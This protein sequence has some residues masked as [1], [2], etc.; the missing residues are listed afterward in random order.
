M[1]LVTLL[2]DR[3]DPDYIFFTTVGTYGVCRVGSLYDRSIA[4]GSPL[5]SQHAGAAEHDEGGGL[6]ARAGAGPA[7][8]SKGGRGSH[9]RV[10]RDILSPHSCKRPRPFRPGAALLPLTAM[11]RPT[12]DPAP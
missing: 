5:P 11:V 3:K 6:G 2:F 4:N 10:A 9:G 8:R 12:R 1:L 7:T